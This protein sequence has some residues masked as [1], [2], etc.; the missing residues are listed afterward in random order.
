VS[1]EKLAEQMLRLQSIGCH[2]INWVTPS[3][4]V[5]FLLRALL[6]AVP[7]GLRIP[8]VYNCGGYES[9]ETLRLLDG[10]V[11]IYMPDFKF[12]DP[13]IGQDLTGVP[14]YPSKAVE[15]LREMHRQVGDLSF[16]TNG[17]AQRGLLIRHLVLPNNL[18]GTKEI[19][20]FLAEG[21]SPRSYVNIM[22]QYRPCGQAFNHPPL[23]RKPKLE[24]ISQARRWAIEAG[25]SRLD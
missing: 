5:P 23:N 22:G 8:L 19:M 7:R 12:W 18:A 13:E 16:D 25:L 21:I 17:I 24:E 3:H 15:A 9:L 14:D 1:P 10:I 6:I 20:T 4:V 11:D 2:N